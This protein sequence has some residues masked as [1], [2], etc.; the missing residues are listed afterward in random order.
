MRNIS[1]KI[2]RFDNPAPSGKEKLLEQEVE[3]S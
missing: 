3:S 2:S 1:V